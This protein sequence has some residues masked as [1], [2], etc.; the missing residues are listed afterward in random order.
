MN[1]I[2]EKKIRR[3]L[4]VPIIIWI[5]VV[6]ISFAWNI[7]TVN[8]NTLRTVKS[9]GRAFFKEIETTRSWNARHGGVYVPITEETQ[10]NPYLKVPNR[11]I[12]STTG[13]SLTKVNPAFMTRQIAEISQ[14]QNEIQYHITSLNPI[15]PANVALDW[16]TRALETFENGAE[17]FFM[18]DETTRNYLYMAPLGV[19][20]ACLPCHSPQGY[21]LGDVRGG[22][23][24]TIQGETH[25]EAA[26]QA[27]NNLILIHG[28]VLVGGIMAY[29]LFWKFRENQMEIL[30][31]KNLRIEESNQQI[32]SSIRYAER[33]QSAM[34]PATEEMNKNLQG[35][36]L[37]HRPKD[38]VSG[39]F[40]WMTHVQDETLIAAV[41]CTGHGVS[42]AFLSMIGHTLLN[43]IVIEDQIVDP[44]QILEHLHTGVRAAL[45]QETGVTRDGMDVCLCRIHAGGQRVTFAGA[46]RPLYYVSQQQFEEIKGDRKSIGGRQKEERRTFTNHDVLLQPGDILYLCSDGV[47]DQPNPDGTRFGSK[48]FKMLLSEVASLPV[49]EQERHIHARLEEYQQNEPQR[50]DIVILGVRI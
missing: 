49:E 22:I 13:V 38:I 4:L 17:E 50:D 19:K 2:L 8:D 5:I 27:K 43:K 3:S 31:E 47:V 35:H 11:D 28:V 36:F 25:L 39:D 34:L 45:Q 26:A 14:E 12:E 42:G 20:E 10:P 18:L 1:R 37:V 44:A 48:Q 23:S 21:E 40:Y 9:V 46:K 7:N 24:V 15:R 41:D 29:S 33:I 16:E 6:S 30:E 32:L